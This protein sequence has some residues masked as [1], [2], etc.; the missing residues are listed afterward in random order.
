M[1]QI[2]QLKLPITHKKEDLEDKIRKTL[3][4]APEQIYDYRIARQSLDARKKQQIH[5]VYTVEVKTSMEEK[6]VKRLHQSNISYRREHPYAFCVTGKEKIPCRPVIAGSG[7][8]GLFCAYFLAASGYR[9]IVLERGKEMKE[10][11]LDVSKFW[12]DGSLDTQSNVQFGEG[13]AGTFSDGKLNTLIKDPVGRSRKVLEIF[14]AHGAPEDILRE[15][16]PHIGTD[17]LAKVIPSIRQ[18]I[19]ADGGDFLFESCLTDLRIQGGE[20]SAVEVNHDTWIDTRLLI[21][22]VGHSARDTFEMLASR[23]VSMEAKAFAVGLRVEHLQDMIDRAQYKDAADQLPP[24]AYKLTAKTPSGRGVYSFCMCP[25]G[26]VVNASS[27]EKRLAING[28]SYRDRAS[29]NANSA[30]IVSVTPD[31][32]PSDHPLGGVSFQR[33]L[34][35]TAFSLAQGAIPQQRYGDFRRQAFSSFGGKFSSLTCGR[36]EMGALHRLF[37]KDIYESFLCGMEQFGRKIP[38][39]DD[40]GVILS[41]VESRTSSPVRIHRDESFQ[42]SVR[43][44]YPCGEGAGYAGGI[45]SAAMDGMKAAETVASQYVP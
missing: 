35:Q 2:Q 38:G 28:M 37:A 11:Y 9:P 16:K 20:L 29:A 17:I 23:G 10:R 8:A 19:I 15:A 18:N 33:T 21:L 45:M 32:F 40:D 6:V 4:L 14:A 34:E 41:G 13:G 43:G 27:E 7:P 30:I 5:Y 24:A 39:F 44:L 22:A 26:F 42:S 1:I 25:G 12:R 36:A 3:K 31:D